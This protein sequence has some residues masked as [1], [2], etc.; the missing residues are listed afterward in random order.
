MELKNKGKHFFDPLV[1]YHGD[2]YKTKKKNRKLI[3]KAI[4]NPD[5]TY[6]SVHTDYE[7]PLDAMMF[8]SNV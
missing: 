6:S 8:S 7:D 1:V 2:D 4:K 5:D 3:A